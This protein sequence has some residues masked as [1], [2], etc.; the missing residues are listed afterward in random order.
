MDII[1]FS[2]CCLYKLAFHVIVD[3]GDDETGE[4]NCVLVILNFGSFQVAG[5]HMYCKKYPF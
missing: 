2:L 5:I 3:S 4:E 1:F